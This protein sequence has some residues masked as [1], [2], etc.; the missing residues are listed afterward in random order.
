SAIVENGAS[1]V[2]PLIDA[3]V[4]ITLE[5]LDGIV[6]GIGPEEWES[7]DD[8]QFSEA[9]EIF[10]LDELFVGERVGEMGVSVGSAGSG[11]AVESGFDSAVADGVHVNDKI[12]FISIYAECC[13]FFGIV[14][15]VAD[16]PDD[17]VCRD[18][19]SC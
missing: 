7:A 14:L 3:G 8:A 17:L 4:E 16:V 5:D 6:A 2:L 11:N 1:R 15:L 12:L 10:G 9:G 13:K 19:S 18:N